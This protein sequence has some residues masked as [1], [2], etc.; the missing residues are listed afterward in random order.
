MNLETINEVTE[1]T[2]KHLTEEEKTI[3]IK[4]LQESELK[5]VQGIADPNS[6]VHE[7]VFN[8]EK[9]FFQRWA[10]ILKQKFFLGAYAK[11]LNTIST[12]IKDQIGRMNLSLDKKENLY[13]N[14]S[15][16]LDAEFKATHENEGQNVSENTSAF[17]P[18]E[19]SFLYNAISIVEKYLES[20]W[21]INGKLKKHM[22]DPQIRKDF[23]DTIYWQEIALYCSTIEELVT[24]IKDHA[25]NS[26]KLDEQLANHTSLKSIEEN[27]NLRQSVDTFRNCLRLLLIITGTYRNWAQKFA[28]SP[29]QHQRVRKRDEDWP[30]KPV[31][32]V[33]QSVLG[34]TICPACHVDLINQKK[35]Y[36]VPP[37]KLF[38]EYRFKDQKYKIPDELKNKGYSPVKI[39]ELVFSRRLKL[40]NTN[41]NAKN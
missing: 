1:L 8:S 20:M 23:E 3:K 38:L 28:I 39:A 9:V 35:Y 14:V 2:A 33:I 13:R 10:A 40:V 30:D 36:D 7:M 12:Y 29:R 37:D 34:S 25:E 32:K 22:E 17:S 4:Q 18:L 24:P 31:Q 5:I 6:I 26:E 19:D 27:F 11:P 15:R 16:S 41:R 21:I